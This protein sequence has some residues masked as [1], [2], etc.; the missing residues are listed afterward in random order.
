MLPKFGAEVVFEDLQQVCSVLVP[1]DL[2]SIHDEGEDMH[3]LYFIL[4]QLDHVF[5][6]LCI[7]LGIVTQAWRIHD[8]EDLLGICPDFV[9]HE[10]TLVGTGVDTRRHVELLLLIVIRPPQKGVAEST[11]TRSGLAHHNDSGYL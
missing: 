9:S 6:E 7:L 2:V 11:L 8:G 5:N 10:F 1:P 3:V 4:D